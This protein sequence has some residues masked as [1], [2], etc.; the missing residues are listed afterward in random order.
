[1]SIWYH[2]RRTHSRVRRP[3][4]KS[5]SFLPSASD[6]LHQEAACINKDADLA[7]NHQEVT[8]ETQMVLEVADYGNTNDH[9]SSD[10]SV[11]ISPATNFSHP[12]ATAT[13]EIAAAVAE[14]LR[15]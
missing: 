12:H 3:I 2:L 15:R 4:A 14:A 6:T 10:M 13:S 8:Q 9:S 11:K 1:M 7:R 5:R